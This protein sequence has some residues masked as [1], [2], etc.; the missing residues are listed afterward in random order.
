MKPTACCQCSDRSDDVAGPDADKNGIRDDIDAYIAKQGY[1]PKQMAAVQQLARGFQ[2]AVMVA[3]SGTVAI[4]AASPIADYLTAAGDCVFSRFPAPGT[5]A[6]VTTSSNVIDT[7]EKITANTKLRVLSY[8][9]YNQAL[10]GTIG[11]LSQG[12]GE[13]RCEN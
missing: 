13:E 6:Y 7:Y 2:R 4:T 11:S 10:D 1:T 12:S 9:R 3:A 5:A 8:L